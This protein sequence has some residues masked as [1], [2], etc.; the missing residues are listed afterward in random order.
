MNMY[1]TLKNGDVYFNVNRMISFFGTTSYITE[2]TWG[3]IAILIVNT[4]GM[5]NKEETLLYYYQKM[6]A[7]LK[8]K[9]V[10]FRGYKRKISQVVPTL[11]RIYG[12]NTFC[13]LEISFSLIR[14]MNS[15]FSFRNRTL[16][17]S[18]G[19]QLSWNFLSEIEEKYPEIDTDELIDMLRK[20]ES[21]TSE[22]NKYTLTCLSKVLLP[23]NHYR[24]SQ[25]HIPIYQHLSLDDFE[26]DNYKI[27]PF[28]NYGDLGDRSSSLYR[29]EL[30]PSVTSPL[31]ME[32]ENVKMLFNWMSPPKERIYYSSGR[33][34]PMILP[35]RNSNMKAKQLIG[36]AKRSTS[37]SNLGQGVRNNTIYRDTDSHFIRGDYVNYLSK[38]LI[39]ED[40]KIIYTEADRNL[41]S[42]M[43]KA[44]LE[45]EMNKI[46]PSEEEIT[47]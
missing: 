24:E 22:M 14:S 38:Q 19:P 30:A 25:V 31:K 37:H 5:D 12:K 8:E 32:F 13:W 46:R 42:D 3:Y 35:E 33:A 40:T 7:E 9:N 34:V 27:L 41:G 2:E 45:S 44:V 4:L 15:W 23:T 11:T 43:L 18:S 39:F 1:Q 36:S 6:V 10:N 47:N 17:N 26:E 29:P 28:S 21:H 16:C 20:P